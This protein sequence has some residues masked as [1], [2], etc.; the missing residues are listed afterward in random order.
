MSYLAA[1]PSRD[2]VRAARQ[3][4][5]RE[6]WDNRRGQFD[7]YI[8]Q[9]VLD[10]AGDGDETAAARRLTLLDGISLLPLS[11]E[12]LDTARSLI[13]GGVLPDN[14][15]GDAVHIAA[16]TVHEMDVLLTWNCRHLANAV[17]LGNVGRHLRNLGY[18]AP[19]IC[20]P[21]ELLGE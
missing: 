10:E 9:F 1:R 21:D 18:E 2:L 20:T 3:E 11:D 14:A 19:I 15:Q 13:S 16:A 4:I 8:S 17:I 6:W 12:V 5:T 7:L